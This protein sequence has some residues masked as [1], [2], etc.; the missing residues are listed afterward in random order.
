MSTP[1]PNPARQGAIGICLAAAIVAAWSAVHVYTIFYLDL[2]GPRLLAA[3]LPMALLC[4]LDVG[5]FI[6]AHDAMHG[7]LVPFRPVL[8]RT[9]GRIC[10][11]LYA[12]F[13]FDRLIG[14]H[15][16]HHRHSG[17]ERDPDF[18]AA[19]PRAFWPWYATFFLRYFGWREFAVMALWFFVYVLVLGASPLNTVLFWAIPSVLASL[20]L[21]FFGTYLPHRHDD[22]GFDTHHNARSNDYP[23]LVSL[24]TCFHFGYHHEHHDDPATPWWRLPRLR[25]QGR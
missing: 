23:V 25:R 11:F 12:G 6:V 1:R 10:L 8:N 9:I 20:Q 7:S 4:W 17:T 14:R 2:S 3:P 15:H 16:D 19:G 21:F 24:L 5:L 22:A 18:H 13:S